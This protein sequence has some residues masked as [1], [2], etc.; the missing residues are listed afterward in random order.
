MIFLPFAHV[1]RILFFLD[2]SSLDH[3]LR[4]PQKPKSVEQLQLFGSLYVTSNCNVS[5]E[6]LRNVSKSGHYI[7]WQP[8]PLGSAPPASTSHT[9]TLLLSGNTKVQSHLTLPCRST[10]GTRT[11]EL[12]V[13]LSTT[14][15]VIFWLVGVSLC[16]QF[17]PL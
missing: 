5:K 12:N 15:K 17:G 2:S 7:L 9:D 16:R 10:Q 11:E 6:I 8:P 3:L 14:Q 13:S 1:Q 4:I